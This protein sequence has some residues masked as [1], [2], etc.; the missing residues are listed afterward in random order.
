MIGSYFIGVFIFA[1]IVG[2]YVLKH[3]YCSVIKV[4]DGHHIFK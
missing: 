1:T 3:I 2:M 4:Q